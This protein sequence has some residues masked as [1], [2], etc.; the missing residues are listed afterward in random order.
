MKRIIA[1]LAL[2]L[3]S[4]TACAAGSTVPGAPFTWTGF[5]MGAHA[6]AAWSDLDVRDTNGGVPAG[7]FNFTAAT[8]AFGGGTLGYNYQHD[9]FVI[10]IEADAG[11]MDQLSDGRIASSNPLYHQNVT[12]GAGMYGDV[13]L[14]AGIAAD[15]T[16]IYVKGGGAFLDGQGTQATT[17]PGY[18]P[19]GTDTFTGF[20]YGGGIEQSL[21]SG[22]SMKV[23]YLHFDFKTAGAMQTSITDPPIGFQYKN[24]FDL[25][26]DTVKLGLNYRF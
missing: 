1:T 19:T 13:T 3:L 14:R 18:K 5:Y 10:G 8:K 23:E 21:G 16:L 17:K 12:V 20:V 6:G 24:T 7:P 22:W 11:Y 25:S 15:R 26:A 9:R 4:A 2:L